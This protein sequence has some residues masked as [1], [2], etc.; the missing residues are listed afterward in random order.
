[1]NFVF[2]VKW[3]ERA[4]VKYTLF[5]NPILVVE[6]ES[7]EKVGFLW[8]NLSLHIWVLSFKSKRFKLYTWVWF[9]YWLI[10]DLSWVEKKGGV[11]LMR[12]FCWI[13]CLWHVGFSWGRNLDFS[14]MTLLSFTC[15]YCW[16][17]SCLYKVGG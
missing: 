13:L 16:I 4:C 5:V 12:H 3:R 7:W 8:Y 1:M 2:G 6:E 10:L 9:R 11:V 17:F 15:S 14:L